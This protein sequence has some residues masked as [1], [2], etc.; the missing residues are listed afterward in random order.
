MFQGR[1]QAQHV[2]SNNLHVNIM[3]WTSVTSIIDKHRKDF[4]GYPYQ[5]L[6]CKNINNLWLLFGLA[7]FMREK[8]G[9]L[10]IITFVLNWSRTWH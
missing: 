2:V 8:S 1:Q 3:F 6:A 5:H 10:K 9:A 7:I 4:I